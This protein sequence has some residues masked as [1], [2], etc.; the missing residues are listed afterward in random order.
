MSITATNVFIRN[1]PNESCCSN[2]A[3]TGLCPKCSALLLTNNV[4][5]KPTPLPSIDWD[6]VFNEDSAIPTTQQQR[7]SQPVENHKSDRPIPLGL[8]VWD[9]STGDER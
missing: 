6:Q 3:V 9:F 1:I 7:Q 2:P 8:P 5:I 4:V